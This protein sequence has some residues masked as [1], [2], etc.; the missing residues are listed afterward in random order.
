MVN[1]KPKTIETLSEKERK[2]VQALLDG[3]CYTGAML[4]A[5]YKRS[6]ARSKQCLVRNRPRVRRALIEGYLRKGMHV[7]DEELAFI[8]K[9]DKVGNED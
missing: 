8:G 7:T 1:D 3:E 6:T 5:G 2:L 9:S 4:D